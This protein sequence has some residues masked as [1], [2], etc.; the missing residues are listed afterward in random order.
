MT[1]KKN[2][3]EMKKIVLA[4]I[5]YIL[6]SGNTFAAGFPAVE[7]YEKTSKSVVLILASDDFSGNGMIGT[8]SIISTD[9]V[10]TNAHVVV[11][12]KA[13]R[14]FKNIR[15]ILKPNKVTGSFRDDLN[16][17][18]IAEVIA[19]DKDIDLAVMRVGDLPRSRGSIELANPDEIKIGEEVVAIGHPEQGGFWTL[20]YGRISA[21]IQN[22]TALGKDVFQTDT[23]LNRG[24]S[25]GPLLDRRGYLVGVNTAIARIGDEN[26]PITG[27]NFSIKSSVVKSWLAQSNISIAYGEKPL[28]EDVKVA[29]V[30]N[31]IQDVPAKE[32]AEAQQKKDEPVIAVPKVEAPK[33]PAVPKVEEVQPKVIETKPQV[34]AAPQAPE[35]KPPIQGQ[36]KVVAPESPEK[37][38]AIKEAGPKDERDAK[39]AKADTKEKAKSGTMYKESKPYTFDALIDYWKKIEQ[40][41]EGDM[42]EM[43]KKIEQIRRR[44]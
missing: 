14:A 8:G 27:V 21:E 18:H 3:G 12:R 39:Q 5:A 40:E 44:H 17:Q 43:Q 33:K 36:P 24:N 1:E 9:M 13:S 15:V 25:G 32:K 22:H 38:Q 34:E 10:L 28:N 16:D 41:L 29:G 11:D 19:F 30:P 35:A 6:L 23:S 20:T 2:G 37:A 26:L 7:V 31:T 42:D 4:F